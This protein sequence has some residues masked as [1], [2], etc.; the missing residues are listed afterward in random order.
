MILAIAVVLAG[1]LVYCV[2]V[3]VAVRS[4]LRQ[5]VPPL[6]ADLP[7]I[8]VLKPLHGIDLGL[9]DN[10]RTFFTQDYP[11]YEILFATRDPADPSLF[12]AE[13]VPEDVI[14]RLRAR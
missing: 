11:S 14:V 3:M 8:S 10:L 12:R 13:P 7:G 1:S 9:E 2:L 4:Y 6:P 5:P